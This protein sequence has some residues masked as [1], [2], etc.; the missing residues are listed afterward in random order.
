MERRVKKTRLEE[1]RKGMRKR[2]NMK[3]GER[4][5]EGQTHLS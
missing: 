4:R 2:R 3:G 1:M 5:R